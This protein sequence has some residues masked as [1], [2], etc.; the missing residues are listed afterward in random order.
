MAHVRH[1]LVQRQ[2]ERKGERTQR[3]GG[4]KGAESLGKSK[5]SGVS[6][7]DSAESSLGPSSSQ[8]PDGPA[9]P[10]LEEDKDTG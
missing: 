4:K 5:R 9:M 10:V 8:V 2:V 1:M 7:T 6:S 3:K